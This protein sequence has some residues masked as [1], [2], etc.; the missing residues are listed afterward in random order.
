MPTFGF[1]DGEANILVRYFALD[2]KTQFPYQT[3]KHVATAEELAV[4]KKLFEGLTCA[5]CHILDGKALAA[6][7]TMSW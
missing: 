3:P 6:S 1:S 4:G 5:K 7:C 2:G